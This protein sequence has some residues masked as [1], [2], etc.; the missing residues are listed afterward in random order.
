[1]DAIDQ[2]DDPAAEGVEH[3]GQIEEA[4][5][6]WNI[7]DVSHPQ[8]V[9]ALRREVAIDEIGRLT[10]SIPDGRD[11]ALATAHAGQAGASHQPGNTFAT[12][13]MPASAR[14]I[15]RRGAPLRAFRGCMRRAD[16]HDQR[17]VPH[18]MLRGRRFPHA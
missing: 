1:V 6:R 14:S 16:L 11:E 8:Q 2:P 3:D 17:G 5:P 7:R 12:D 9:R 10:R 4:G 15:C 13:T 18:R